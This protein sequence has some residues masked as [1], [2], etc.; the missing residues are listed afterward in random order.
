MTQLKELSILYKIFSIFNWKVVQKNNYL[1]LLY[2]AQSKCK[3]FNGDYI[4]NKKSIMI[5]LN[6][7]LKFIEFLVL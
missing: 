5:L 1:N 4:I 2:F 3:T 7:I 6:I